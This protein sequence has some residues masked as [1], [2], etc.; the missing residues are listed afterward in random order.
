MKNIKKFIL[1][2]LEVIQDAKQLQVKEMKKRY[3]Q[4]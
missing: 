2:V 4:R 1:A 3:F